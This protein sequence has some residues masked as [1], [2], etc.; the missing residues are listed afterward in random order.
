MSSRKESKHL[1]GKGNGVKTM[2]RKEAAVMGLTK[3]ETGRPCRNGHT[4]YRY[5]ASGTCSCCINGKPLNMN[6][7][8]TALS[9]MLAEETVIIT[10][11]GI[12]EIFQQIKDIADLLNG[13]KLP[14]IP[15]N[16]LNLYPF[17][18]RKVR[19]SAGIHRVQI[20]VPVGLQEEA[21]YLC[22]SLMPRAFK[23]L[24]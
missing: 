20:A 15:P 22:A 2:E 11:Y 6:D 23:A 17:R 4:T 9:K 19:Y 13:V 7:N 3:Y 1:R 18:T 16:Y 24:A 8:R 10:V 12:P 5:T 21:K 14:H